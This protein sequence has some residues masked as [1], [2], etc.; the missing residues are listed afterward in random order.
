[1]NKTFV[2][3]PSLSSHDINDAIQERISKSQ[4]ITTC[5]LAADNLFD[6]NRNCLYGVIWTLDSYLN[7]LEILVEK[8]ASQE[9][10]ITDEISKNQTR[11]S[12]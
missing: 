2:L 9:K 4:A 12:T 11:S 8:I 5:L 1:M 3:N 7:E 10:K 6:P